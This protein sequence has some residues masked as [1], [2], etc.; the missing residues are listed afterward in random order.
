MVS[1]FEVHIVSHYRAD[2]ARELSLV[3]EG[4]LGWK[5]CITNVVV[6]SNNTEYETSGLIGSFKGRFEQLGH[7]LSLNVASNL[8]NPRHLTWEHKRFIRPWMETASPEEDFFVYI[9]DDIA[10]SNENVRYFIRNRQRLS[11]SSLIPGFLRY[12]LKDDEKRLVDVM[13]PEYWERDRTRKIDGTLYHS[14]INP[15]WAG[16]ILDL[17]LAREYVASRSFTMKD[18]EFV[19]WN[20]QERAAMGL[21]FEHPSPH[22]RSRLVVPII[23]GTPDPACLV[24]H[25]SNSYTADDHP[26]MCQLSIERAF[27]REGSPHY[28]VRKS[29][30][31]LRRLTGSRR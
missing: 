27:V 11:S 31:A 7:R 16:F 21:T 5:N 23:D 4:L 19:R 8:D 18:S 14:C 30:A 22:F 24:W 29:R 26:Q 17:A 13:Y 15:Y 25:C 28:L 6:T 1:R 10:L 9:E 3:L 2:R 20:V 12:E